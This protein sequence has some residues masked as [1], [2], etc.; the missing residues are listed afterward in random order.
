MGAIIAIYMTTDHDKTSGQ[1]VISIYIILY[2]L[3]TL[4]RSF[5]RQY[6]YCQ[7]RQT[8]K[9]AIVYKHV[10]IQYSVILNWLLSLYINYTMLLTRSCKCCTGRTSKQLTGP[11]Q[12]SCSLHSLLANSRLYRNSYSEL[13]TTADIWW[14]RLQPH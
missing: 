2:I 14:P 10:Y 8:V 13:L 3:F 11:L 4:I 5:W 1:S 7:C 12:L 9:L 6:V